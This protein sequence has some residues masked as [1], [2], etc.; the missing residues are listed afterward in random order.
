[1]ALDH[2]FFLGYGKHGWEFFSLCP[3]GCGDNNGELCLINCQVVRS[4]TNFFEESMQKS[5]FD[6]ENGGILVMFIFFEKLPPFS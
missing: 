6:E 4:I 5:N 2:C 3:P 1:L